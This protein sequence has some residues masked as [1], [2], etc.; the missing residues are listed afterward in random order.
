MRIKDLT[1]RPVTIGR[2]AIGTRN[3]K[4]WPVKLDHFIFTKPKP[5]S[6][7]LYERDEEVTMIM[8]EAYG[9]NPK[10]IDVV[11]PFH[12][13]EENFVTMYACYKDATG[14]PVCKGDGETATRKIGDEYQVVP[15]NYE[16]CQFKFMKMKN[17]QEIEAC[18]PRGILYVYLPRIKRLGGVFTFRTSSIISVRQILSALDEIYA[19][20]QKA[21]LT[22]KHLMCKMVLEPQKVE[23]N[24]KSQIVYTVR[25]E[26]S[27]SFEEA[28]AKELMAGTQPSAPALDTSPSKGAL[29]APQVVT[30]VA[31]DPFENAPEFAPVVDQV[32]AV[33]PQAVDPVEEVAAPATEYVDDDDDMF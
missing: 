8:E 4:G 9:E 12:T 3:E 30:P 17:G 16:Q 7:G 28:V 24:G 5:N 22:L 2:I 33:E 6:K 13:P 18:K 11:L 21:G 14:K 32:D 20:R 27:R 25:L 31:E 15:C 23:V 26:W 19:I 10:V 29:Q 1:T